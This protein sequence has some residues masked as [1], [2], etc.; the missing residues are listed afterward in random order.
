MGK[1][2]SVLNTLGTSGQF[3]NNKNAGESNMV[4]NTDDAINT[5]A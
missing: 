3:N 2:K 5:S 1:G 4:T